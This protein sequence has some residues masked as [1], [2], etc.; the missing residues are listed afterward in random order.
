MAANEEAGRRLTTEPA[1]WARETSPRG[2]PSVCKI[3]ALCQ[4]AFLLS[5]QEHPSGHGL[6]LNYGALQTLRQHCVVAGGK[7]VRMMSTVNKRKEKQQERPPGSAVT[8]PE[9]NL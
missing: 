6:T 5:P 3:A 7:P 2:R 8:E 4:Q 9:A 1:T